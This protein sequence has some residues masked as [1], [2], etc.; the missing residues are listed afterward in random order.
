MV[1]GLHNRRPVEETVLPPNEYKTN[2][3]SLD[4]AKPM[5]LPSPPCELTKSSLVGL[6]L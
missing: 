3:V 5:Q 1:P 2:S 6:S 4:C